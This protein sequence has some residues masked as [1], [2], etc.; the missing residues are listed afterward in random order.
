MAADF[1][2]VPPG[3]TGKTNTLAIVSVV[4]GGLG[5]P[6]GCCGVLG[7]PL[8]LAALVCGGIA[9]SQIGKTREQGRGLAIT[10]L[11]LGAVAL[12]LA[13]AMIVFG[14]AV[15]LGQFDLQKFQNPQIQQQDEPGLDAG[16][17][18]GEG[19][20]PGDVAE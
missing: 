18:E 15:Q 17:R 13:I 11:A 6:L 19:Q 12:V 20:P 8:A 16:E 9:L 7:L 1:N 3:P 5:L 4:C 2:T 10:G 14:A